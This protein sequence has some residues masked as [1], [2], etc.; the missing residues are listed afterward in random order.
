MDFEAPGTAKVVAGPGAGVRGLTRR[1]DAA[2]GAAALPHSFIRIRDRV[3]VR[4]G[5]IADASATVRPLRIVAA[6]R[7]GRGWRF[8]AREEVGEEGYRIGDVPA[9]V[10]IY[11][12]DGVAS[13]ARTPQK[14]VVQ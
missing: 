13:R 14:Q 4:D 11:V 9:A 8:P 6:F 5:R 1:R 12:R 2:A 10:G 3:R 7:E